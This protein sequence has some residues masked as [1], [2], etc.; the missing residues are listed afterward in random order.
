MRR[1]LAPVLLLLATTAQ[2]DGQASDRKIFIDPE[3]GERRAPTTDELKQQANLPN[4][5]T[6]E[7]TAAPMRTADGIR[8]YRLGEQHRSA[9]RA[10]RSDGGS[11]L[12]IEH[13][14]GGQE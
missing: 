7:A 14:Q 13:D 11:A 12:H 5:R 6:V 9:L 2:A 1:L 4:K 8:I 3:T 10:E